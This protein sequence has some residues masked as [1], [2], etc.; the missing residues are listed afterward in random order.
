MYCYCNLRNAWVMR[1]CPRSRF[2]TRLTGEAPHNFGSINMAAAGAASTASGAAGADEEQQWGGA[3]TSGSMSK[4]LERLKSLHQRA[5]KGTAKVM[6]VQVKVVMRERPESV[7]KIVQHLKLIGYDIDAICREADEKASR[8]RRPSL[9]A[10]PR[11]VPGPASVVAE[12]TLAVDS[13]APLRG[14]RWWTVACLNPKYLKPILECMDPVHMSITPLNA[15]VPHGRREN[16]EVYLELLELGGNVRPG[17]RVTDEMRNVQVWART[18]RE[19]YVARGEPCSKVRLCLPMNWCLKGV[20]VYDW[21]VVDADTADYFIVVTYM[22]TGEEARLDPG[23]PNTNFSMLYIDKGFPQ[24]DAQLK[25]HK[26]MLSSSLILLSPQL[27]GVCQKPKV[28]K[29]FL[30]E[31]DEHAAPEGSVSGSASACGSVV[32]VET[33]SGR[34]VNIAIAKRVDKN[35]TVLAAKPAAASATAP[36]EAAQPALAQAAAVHAGAT[37]MM[38]TLTHGA[39]Q[40]PEASLLQLLSV[41]QQGM[42]QSPQA[43]GPARKAGQTEREFTPRRPAITDDAA[44]NLQLVDSAAGEEPAGT[45]PATPAKTSTTRK[46]GRPGSSNEDGTGGKQKKKIRREWHSFHSGHSGMLGAVR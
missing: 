38:R 35:T 25:E 32:Q 19:V 33:S 39:A 13:L 36:D 11:P 29:A 42:Q 30:E 5:S 1:R 16:K 7:Q 45:G 6:E 15:M 4:E 8:T 31:V 37:D 27:G 40:I 12:E 22:I 20:G 9:A 10:L 17:D 46:R 34:A 44:T 3:R 26:G 21:R 24:H 28:R 43:A 14:D 41:L 2:G 23:V 18:L